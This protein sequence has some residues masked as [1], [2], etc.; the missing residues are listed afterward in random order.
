MNLIPE[1]IVWLV[2]TDSALVRSEALPYQ[3][4]FSQAKC[5]EDGRAYTANVHH[6]ISDH[7]M[8][9]LA[10]S[11]DDIYIIMRLAGKAFFN[12]MN[13]NIDLCSQ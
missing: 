6:N 11:D 1:E 12:A 3:F 9:I 5:K 4:H 13:K 8:N 2:D 10:H 7:E